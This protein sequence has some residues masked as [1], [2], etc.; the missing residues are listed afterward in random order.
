LIA[1]AP[2]L[3]F[4]TRTFCFFA[5]GVDARLQETRTQ[6]V[7]LQ[8]IE[9][10][11]LDRDPR[12]TAR[13]VTHALLASARTDVLAARSD[14]GAAALTAE[15]PPGEDELALSFGVEGLVVVL[16]ETRLI[17]IPEILRDDPQ[18][19]VLNDDA[20]RLRREAHLHFVLAAFPLG[21]A[22]VVLAHVG[23]VAQDPDT[24]V[25]IA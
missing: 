21:L 13:V 18:L 4:H 3:I 11:L 1:L 16:G 22:I 14:R 10:T 19:R 24:A 6:Q 17:P 9:H 8:P 25:S 15:D 5:V 2:R 7:L 12:R 23:R 20:F